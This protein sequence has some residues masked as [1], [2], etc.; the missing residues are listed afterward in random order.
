MLRG[1]NSVGMLGPVPD[2]GGLSPCLFSP[3]VCQF[4]VNVIV[5]VVVGVIVVVVLVVKVVKVVVVLSVLHWGS[6]TVTA[7]EALG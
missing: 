3:E 1:S 7:A 5:R 2:L 4:V 6:A